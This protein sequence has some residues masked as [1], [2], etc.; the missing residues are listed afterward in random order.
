[1]FCYYVLVGSECYFGF[2]CFGGVYGVVDFVGFVLRFLLFGLVGVG[3]CSRLEGGVVWVGL[4]VVW[5][6]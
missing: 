3:V 4:V 2:L 1:M 6:V 5:G